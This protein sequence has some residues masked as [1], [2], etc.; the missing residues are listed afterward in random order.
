MFSRN[1]SRSIPE[2]S[3]KTPSSKPYIASTAASSSNCISLHCATLFHSSSPTLASMLLLL[4]L[5]FCAT[6]VASSCNLDL[7]CWYGFCTSSCCFAAFCRSSSRR[8]AAAA[9][10]N[11]CLYCL[12]RAVLCCCCS[13]EEAPFFARIFS[14]CVNFFGSDFFLVAAE[15]PPPPT[16]ALAS[17]QVKCVHD[18]LA[19]IYQVLSCIVLVCCDCLL[20]LFVVLVCCDGACALYC[21]LRL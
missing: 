14:T 19:A 8:F 13:L 20:C 15:S 21:A 4:L 2:C 11:S 5:S 9:A 7:A 3:I 6:S 17:D 12:R 18:F 10:R 1:S 16:L